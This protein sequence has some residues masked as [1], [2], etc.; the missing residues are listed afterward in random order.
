MLE[1]YHH[2]ILQNS[3]LLPIATGL[4]VLLVIIRPGDLTDIEFESTKN[5]I[6]PVEIG[7]QE[8]LT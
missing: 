7:I 2:I 1:S 8:V 6:D 3:V 5:P 4:V